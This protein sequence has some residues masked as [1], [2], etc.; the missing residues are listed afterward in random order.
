MFSSVGLNHDLQSTKRNKKILLNLIDQVGARYKT[1]LYFINAI[2]ILK[3]ISK[4]LEDYYS[5]VS[6][7]VAL[8]LWIR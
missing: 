7:Q 5:V 8:I 6:E 4:K 2:I 3:T 1:F